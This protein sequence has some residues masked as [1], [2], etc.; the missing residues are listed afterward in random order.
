MAFTK[1][2]RMGFLLISVNMISTNKALLRWDTKWQDSAPWVQPFCF[3]LAPKL[4]CSDR[5]QMLRYASRF[6]EH[7]QKYHRFTMLWWI[8]WKFRGIL[9]KVLTNVIFLL[10]SIMYFLFRILQSA[11]FV[12]NIAHEICIE[13][14]ILVCD[15]CQSISCKSKCQICVFLLCFTDITYFVSV[16]YNSYNWLLALTMTWL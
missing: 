8:S 9:G 7:T 10:H 15:W 11:F 1:R 5:S 12:H 6:I 3:V 2:F 14:T 16:V 4:L 13:V